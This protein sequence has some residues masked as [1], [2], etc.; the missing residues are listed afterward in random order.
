VWV[1]EDGASETVTIRISKPRHVQR[2]WESAV[3]LD[4]ISDQ[5]YYVRGVDSFQAV[6]LAM[7]FVRNV[8]DKQLREG[9]KLLWSDRSG[10]INLDVMF[11]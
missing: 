8:L 11:S 4:G 7:A 2:L 10:E 5:T 9:S 3:V 6:C 1:R